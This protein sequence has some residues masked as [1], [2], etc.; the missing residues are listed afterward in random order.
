MRSRGTRWAARLPQ[1]AS[2]WIGLAVPAGYLLWTLRI[3]P[4]AREHLDAALLL[5][6]S[7]LAAG[8]VIGGVALLL[9]HRS[10]RTWLGSISY[11]SALLYLG[12]FKVLGWDALPW[13]LLLGA[14]LVAALL[15]RRASIRQ[16]PSLLLLHAMGTSSGLYLFFHLRGLL[17]AWGAF[18]SVLAGLWLL[19]A[20]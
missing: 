13:A 14:C 10:R 20:R 4:G 7:S 15:H 8:T 1:L 3:E 6:A 16:S 9:L 12:C 5:Y 18:R 19:A 11:A 2:A 17:D